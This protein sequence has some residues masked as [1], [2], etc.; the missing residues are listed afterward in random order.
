MPEN[1]SES[2]IA[3]ENRANRLYEFKKY[4]DDIP[5]VI[6]ILNSDRKVIYA[7]SEMRRLS[8]AD[9]NTIIGAAAGSILGCINS[10]KDPRGCGYSDNCPCCPL[11]KA[12]NEVFQSGLS[13]KNI[14]FNPELLVNGENKKFTFICTVTSLADSRPNYAALSFNDIT[15]VK[16]MERE[17]LENKD[18]LGLIFKMSPDA[19]LI[20]RADNGL[21]VNANDS[22]YELSGYAQEEIKGKTTLELNLFEAADREKIVSSIIK[23]GY[24]IN[25][26][27]TFMVKNGHKIT[28]LL[29][30]RIINLDETQHII[31][32]VRNITARKKIEDDLRES[33]AKFRGYIDASPE[34]I[35]VVDG[36]GRY[37]EVNKEAVKNT[38][39]SKEELLNTNVIE[40]LA[41][42]STDPKKDEEH[43]RKLIQTGSAGGVF[44][45][46][47]KN[48]TLYYCMLKA[49]KINDNL[50][51]GFENDITELMITEQRL[52]VSEKRF[53][54]ILNT[55]IAGFFIADKNMNIIEVNDHYCQMSGYSR[56]ELLKFKVIDIEAEEKKEEHNNHSAKIILIGYDRFETKHIRKNGEVY[57]VE[58]SISY[59]SSSGQ[60]LAFATDISIRKTYEKA[61]IEAKKAAEEASGAKSQFLAN[62]SH[63][64]RTPLNSI[65]GYADLLS[66][67]VNISG[68]PKNYI[69]S[70]N[71]SARSL[72]AIINDILDLSKIEAG[73]LILEETM[74]DL[75]KLLEQTVNIFKLS[76]LDKKLDLILNIDPATPQY[77]KADQTRLRQVL[78]NLLS[79]AIKFTE[80]GEVKVMVS[81]ITAAS[82]GPGTFTFMV[83]DTGIG[84]GENE[85]KIL[86]QAFSQGDASITRKFGGSGLGLI[87]SSVL[88]KK[89]GG[90]IEL[91]SRK[92]IGSE[93]YF[94][95]N[96]EFEYK[97][98]A[99]GDCART[100][101][102]DA[103]AG[104]V[105]A[106]KVFKSGRSFTPIIMIAEDS[107]MNMKLFSSIFKKLVPSAVIICAEDGEAA[108]ELYKE[109]KPDIIFMD[110]QMPVI[111]GYE[112]TKKIRELEKLLTAK[113]QSIIIALTASA[114]KGEEEKCL[115]AGMDGFMSKPLDYNA[116]KEIVEKYVEK[117]RT[118][119]L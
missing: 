75:Y 114:I 102:P 68:E 78:I 16:T 115:Q 76:A 84:I 110:I 52:R 105:K 92:S 101:L 38:G 23:N 77:M 64:I 14:T 82:D 83:M 56:E 47:R 108:F 97:S 61:I 29:S 53:H 12:I 109:S 24:C 40:R 69:D 10:F 67:D 41:F 65:I 6:I 7:N 30:A 85:K 81:F 119:Y 13:Q 32:V 44:H 54:A 72:L 88:V 103:L 66:L 36:L 100:V 51:I 89:M 63:E 4:Y 3:G 55:Y 60:F 106:D 87:I 5:V 31:S 22:F 45:F 19:I 26:E 11:F 37:V 116:L 57:D 98:N 8:G 18:R 39:F 2:M 74:I 79:N 111:D 94:T 73:K 28:G 49:V 99:S 27:H 71:F 15:A 35:F 42:C 34:S 33:E 1:S 21:I 91:K 113:K 117:I 80:T 9:D 90:D 112:A 58:M 107:P 118:G 86:F 17:S 70:I 59:E 104:K 96:R 20:T 93:F 25:I 95:L 43:F 50:F 62:M 48:G 46:K